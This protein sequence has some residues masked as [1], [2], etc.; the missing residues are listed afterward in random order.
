MTKSNIALICARGGSKGLPGKNLK[1]LGDKSLIGH[2]IDIGLKSPSIDRVFVSTDCSDI[3]EEATRCGA[4]VPFM[5]RE[6]LATDNASEWDAWKDAAEWFLNN[7]IN[8]NAMV[9]LSPTAPL[10]SVENVEAAIQLFYT[11]PCDGVISVT[12]AHR[13]PYFNMVT[14][15]EVGVAKIGI[16]TKQPL[17]RRQDAP[18][19]YDITTVCYVMKPSY[20]MNNVHLFDGVIQCNHIP[21]ENSI[22]IDTPFDFMLAEAIMK[23]SGFVKKG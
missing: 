11:Q 19:F 3:A 2:A 9:M 4:E 1:R 23:W 15:N 12:D 10:R 14:V 21:E 13:N 8:C 17:Y 6:E 7:N 5:R 18:S 22:D 16:E 20:I